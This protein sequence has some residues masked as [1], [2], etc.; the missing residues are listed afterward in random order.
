MRDFKIKQ[1]IEMFEN[2]L[3]ELKN[4]KNK[5]IEILT[6]LNEEH[7]ELKERISDIEFEREKLKTK[8]ETLNIK[9]KGLTIRME[10]LKRNFIANEI[11]E[12]LNKEDLKTLIEKY[13]WYKK[14]D[15]NSYIQKF[16]KETEN[17][18]KENFNPSN[19]V[20]FKDGFIMVEL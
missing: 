17:K 9:I 1:K 18:I 10:V 7:S 4:Q 8:D 6:K 2:E 14:Q 19:S 20:I 11:E 3:N 5:I 13:Q 12:N 16:M 15:M